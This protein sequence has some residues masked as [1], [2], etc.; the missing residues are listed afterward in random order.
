MWKGDLLNLQIL[1]YKSFLFWEWSPGSM[2]H[3]DL[4]WWVLDYTRPLGSRGISKPDLATGPASAFKGRFPF[5]LCIMLIRNL[6]S[7]HL[8]VLHVFFVKNVPRIKAKDWDWWNDPESWLFRH[9][10]DIKDMST[11]QVILLL[12]KSDCGNNIIKC[13]WPSLIDVINQWGMF[14]H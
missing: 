5:L 14:I 9:I 7:S 2:A 1:Y 10:C 4:S 12:Q 3:W 11:L 6:P 8:V 13:L